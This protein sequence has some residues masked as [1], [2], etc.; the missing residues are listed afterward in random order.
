MKIRSRLAST[1]SFLRWAREL[2][3]SQASIAL[4]TRIR[5]SPPARHTHGRYSV[6]G[7]YPSIKMGATIQ[8]ESHRSEYH[9]VYNFEHDPRVLEYYDQ[10]GK[11]KLKYRDI[12]G[13]NGGCI[14]TP[15]F[16]VIYD[17]HAGYVECKPLDQLLELAKE[18]PNRYVRQSDGS[19][20][21]P[22][23][24]ESAAQ[25][26]LTYVLFVPSEKTGTLTRNLSFLDDYSIR[27]YVAPSPECITKVQ[28]TVRESQGITYPELLA[29]LPKLTTDD[30]NYLISTGDVYTDLRSV[31]LA[32]PDSVTFFSDRLAA[33]AF[34]AVAH[35]ITEPVAADAGPVEIVPTAQVLINGA[36]HTLTNVTDEIISMIN[37]E[38][39]TSF[40]KRCDFEE[41]V[42][43]G[44]I[45]RFA[46]PATRQQEIFAKVN[47]ASPEHSRKAVDAWKRIQLFVTKGTS[48]PMKPKKAR[49]T[50][51][52]HI[53][54][55][56]LAE[57]H[58]GCGFIGLLP[59]ARPGNRT[60]RFPEEVI[61]MI[62]KCIVEKYERTTGLNIT[63]AYHQLRRDCETKGFDY[64]SLNTFSKYVN[65]R[66]QYEQMKKREGKRNAYTRKNHY[67]HLDQSTPIHGDRPW[68]IGHIDHTQLDIELK[69]SRTGQ[70][71]GRPWLTLLIDAYSRRILAISLSF[72]PPSAEACMRILRVCVQRHHRAPQIIIVDNGKEFDGVYF[73]Q[74]LARYSITKKSRPPATPRFGSV[75]ERVFGTANTQFI[76]NLVGNTK[77]TKKVRTITKAVNPKL[78]AAWTLEDL[79]ESLSEYCF[80]VYD[81]QDHSTLGQ[82]PRE[83]YNQ[84]LALSGTRQHMFIA[85][86][87]VFNILTLPT[88]KSGSAKVHPRKGVHLNY[89]DYWCDAFKDPS[90]EGQ[91]VPIRYDPW[92]ASV[93][94]AYVKLKWHPCVSTLAHF[95]KGRS[96]RSIEAA[97]AELL[98]GKSDHG[99][100]VSVTSRKLADFMAKVAERE[101]VL[102]ARVSEMATR[103]SN[104]LLLGRKEEDNS[105]AD[106]IEQLPAAPESGNEVAS[107]A[108][109]KPKDPDVE[110]LLTIE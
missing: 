54:A 83:A 82:S 87:A 52:R 66:P 22:P 19:W 42:M 11:V 5:N 48:K 6:Q 65:Q 80:E 28:T 25:F 89:L 71:L 81:T 101:D 90:I 59:K 3:L 30:L 29:N 13:R 98:K 75:C 79:T 67:L 4:I 97:S 108:P 100:R 36:Q 15:D 8:F 103:A 41:L 84:G 105:S 53:A 93:A 1:A 95:F 77:L 43:N 73:E 47:G 56:H 10:P 51:Y 39:K 58:T 91:L 106:N 72:S 9:A 88:T 60:P 23:G 45:R 26:G 74:L 24:E 46:P 94:Y 38:G 86:D 92:D 107:P 37:H 78:L 31:L 18:M 21:C 27:S 44:S 32:D 2:K 63:T 14:H 62:N 35:R 7:R 17:D 85:F 76:H 99:K 33:E 50:L 55:Y 109:A 64:P 16:F 20:R 68:E 12:S 61:A 110:F 49:A 102:L 34:A 57:Q 70:N 69:C 40:R 96:I 104:N